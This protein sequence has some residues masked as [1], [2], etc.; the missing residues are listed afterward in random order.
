[1]DRIRRASLLD[2]TAPVRD[3]GDMAPRVPDLV[4]HALQLG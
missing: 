1:M 2:E 4:A 3:F